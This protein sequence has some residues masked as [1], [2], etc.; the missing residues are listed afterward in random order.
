M[1]IIPKYQGGGNFF[2]FLAT[3]E[4][5]QRPASQQPAQQ[6][7]RSSGNNSGSSDKGKLT[8]KD[9]FSKLGDIDGLPNEMQDVAFKIQR[10]YNG[11]S[12]TSSSDLSSIYAKSIVQIKTAKFNKE[13]YDQALK[14]VQTNEGLNEFAINS[15]GQMV[16]YNK[17]KEI[18]QI[19]VQEYLKNSKDYQPLT[20]SNI[21]WLRAHDPQFAWN[22]QL[23]DIVQNGIG[24]NKVVEL[25][26]TR[27]TS[28]GTTDQSIEGYTSREQGEIKKGI[29]ILDEAASKQLQSGMTVDGLYKAKIITKDQ[30]TQAD[31]ALKYIYQTLPENAKAIL[32]LHAGN[33][34]N[35]TKGALDIIGNMILSKEDFTSS[36]SLDYQ[37]ELNA[38]GTKRKSASSGS[39]EDGELDGIATDTWNA[40]SLLLMGKGQQQMITFNP[41]TDVAFQ[42]LV[43]SLPIVKANG[44]P[45]GRNHTLNALTESQYAGVLDFDKATMG[46]ARID[47]NSFGRIIINSDKISTVDFPV[48]ANGNPDLRPTTVSKKREADKLIKQA[49]IDLSNEQSVAKNADKIN[50]IL[51][52]VGL[53][54]AYNSSGKIAS[55]NWKRFAILNATAD[56]R[57][58]GMGDLDENKW[59]REITDD[60][61]I[62]QMIDILKKEN[63]LDKYKFDKNEW[64]DLNGHDSFYQGTVWIPLIEDYIGAQV[65]SGPVKTRQIDYIN[66]QT[67]QNALY[68]NYNKPP[69]L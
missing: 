16:V 8:E 53:S 17:D 6:Q 48:D 49:G 42:C 27:M 5:I 61:Q 3:Y 26:K 60:D 9:L 57:A 18:N 55:G 28:L 52:Q 36:V 13:A 68:Q 33:K 46:G 43:N 35:P 2:P 34:D 12:L 44:D 66:Q 63:D 50:E 59:L 62:D 14:T 39:G 1:K 47:D 37:S 22:N 56:G 4:P 69:T 64:Y 21:L 45:L 20:N 7:Q 40:A 11:I 31:A 23:F 38:D 67:I 65:G 32:M 41:G 29:E 15:S 25:I 54:A 10:M 51:K 24:I 30:K 58:L 19:S